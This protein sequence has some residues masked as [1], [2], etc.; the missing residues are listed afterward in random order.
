MF[1]VLEMFKEEYERLEKQYDE[2]SGGFSE[3]T[4]DINKIR[5]QVLEAKEKEI[6]LEYKLN[7]PHVVG[8]G[9][10]MIAYGNIVG[11]EVGC[12]GV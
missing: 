1:I 12:K 9:Y 2:Q 3:L 10:R 7:K 8:S 5:D 6:S 4:Y 11:Y